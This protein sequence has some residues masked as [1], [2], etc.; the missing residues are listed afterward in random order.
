MISGFIYFR[1]LSLL[2]QGLLGKNHDK[3][4]EGKKFYKEN[5]K[6]YDNT[7]RYIIKMISKDCPF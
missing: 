4:E 5:A 1:F 3:T 6:K 7:R 2:W